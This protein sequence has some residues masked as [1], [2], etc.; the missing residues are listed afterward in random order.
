MSNRR[1]RP[2]SRKRSRSRVYRRQNDEDISISSDNLDPVIEAAYRK[3]H[4]DNNNNNNNNNNNSEKR[5]EKKRTV[6][7]LSQQVKRNIDEEV[8]EKDSPE[9][10]VSYVHREKNF[11][12]KVNST[13]KP[14]LMSPAYFL[15]DKSIALVGNA[16]SLFDGHYGEVIDSYDVVC[17]INRGFTNI[18]PKFHLS[19]G[20][21]TDILFI[22]LFKTIDKH[23]NLYSKTEMLK[24][25]YFFFQMSDT[26]DSRD[27][28]KMPKYIFNDLVEQLGGYNP[29]TGMRCLYYLH[30]QISFKKCGIFG[31][32]WKKTPSYFSGKQD[33]SLSNHNFEREMEFCFDTIISNNSKINY[34]G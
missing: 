24:H 8:S 2:N 22:N 11:S 6:S 28:E 33:P 29:S 32:D 26:K 13:S 9:Q 5:I 10:Q 27:N 21:R 15:K 25:T 1:I 30:N 4:T 7:S 14:Y 12:F 17:R 19:T 3:R 16:N 34:Y 18:I 23:I 20:K 31:F